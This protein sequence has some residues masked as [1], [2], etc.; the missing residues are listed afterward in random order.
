MS[1]TGTE[2][3]TRRRLVALNVG[4][5]VVLGIVTLS[6]NASG[7][8]GAGGTRGR[9]DY[10]VVSGKYTGSTTNALYILDAA[11]LELAVLSWDRNQ[12]QLSIIGYRS[13]AD[14]AKFQQQP[15]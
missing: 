3:K 15:R 9:G 2:G 6:G 8:P 1:D 5:L 13:V 4:L 14:D 7:Q 12:N 11:N 10:T